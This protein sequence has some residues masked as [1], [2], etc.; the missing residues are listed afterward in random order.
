VRT[1]GAGEFRRY[2]LADCS[3]IVILYTNEK[4]E[5]SAGHLDAAA[6]VSGEEEP[7]LDGCLAK[8]LPPK[9]G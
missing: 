4:G 1:E 5:F 9:A 3:L 2:A 7:D 8:G 6:K